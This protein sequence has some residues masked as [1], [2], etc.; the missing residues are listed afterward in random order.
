M[1]GEHNSH[2]LSSDL[3]MYSSDKEFINGLTTLT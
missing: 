3:H 2:K 1:V